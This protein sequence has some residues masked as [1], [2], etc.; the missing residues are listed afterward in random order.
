[1]LDLSQ[2]KDMWMW[3]YS[4][5][6]LFTVI[7]LGTPSVYAIILYGASRIITNVLGGKRR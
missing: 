5:P 1:M 2:T 4:H 3:A 6:Y 7:K